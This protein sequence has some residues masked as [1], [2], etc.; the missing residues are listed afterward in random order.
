MVCQHRGASIIGRKLIITL[1]LR[2][3]GRT[4]TYRSH[5]GELTD[6]DVCQHRLSSSRINS[7]CE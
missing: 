7:A 3:N 4:F 2:F 6:R 5:F 1:G